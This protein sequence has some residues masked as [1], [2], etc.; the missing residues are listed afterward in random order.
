MR[1]AKIALMLKLD[2]RFIRMGSFLLFFY[3]WVCLKLSVINFK[4]IE[5]RFPKTVLDQLILKNSF[6]FLCPI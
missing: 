4:R 1:L 6:L 2:D 3:L 5:M